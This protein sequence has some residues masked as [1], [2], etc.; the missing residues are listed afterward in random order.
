MANSGLSVFDGINK[1]NY[2]F[3]RAIRNAAKGSP[4]PGVAMA[5]DKSIPTIAEIKA[6]SKRHSLS[7]LLPYESYDSERELY[8]NTDSVGFMLYAFPAVGLSNNQLTILN[9]ILA[10][11]HEVDTQIQI[12]L[13][14]SPDVSAQTTAWANE[15]NGAVNSKNHNV[16]KTLAK[17]RTDYLSTGKWKSLFKDQSWSPRDYHLI[18]SY[19]VTLHKGMLEESL[20]DQFLTSLSDSKARIAGALRGAGIASI[21]LQPE[22]FINLLSGV[23]NPSESTPPKLLYNEN[24]LINDQILDA[25]TAFL[26]GSHGS[27]IRHADASYSVLPFHVRQWPRQWAGFNNGELLGAINNNIT[28]IGY[29]F[30]ATLAVDFG[31]PVNFKSKVK[32]RSLRATQMA[33]SPVSKYVPEWQDR[34]RD[35]DFVSKEIADGSK[36]ADMFYQIVLFAPQGDEQRAEQN[37]K[38]VYISLGWELSKSAYMP[39]HS[40]LAA[41]PMGITGDTKAALKTFGH[42][43]THL[44]S[45]AVNCAPWIGEWK[46]STTAAMLLHGRRGQVITWDPYD[47]KKGNYNIA[48]AAK[49]GAGKSFFSQ[50]IISN[51]LSSGGRAV[52]IDSGH[53]Y[54][55]IAG[56]FDGSYIEFDA[57]N[58]IGLNPFSNIDDSDP[59]HFKEQLPLLKMMLCQ[60]SGNEEKI[61]NVHKA[62]LERAIVKAWSVHKR[63]TTITKVSAAIGDLKLH[64][65]QKAIGEALQLTLYSYTAEGMYG[66]YFEGDSNIS[67]DNDF[68]VLELSGL[69]DTPDLQGVVLLY[70]I[71]RITQRMYHDLNRSQRDICI[72]DEAWKLLRDGMTGE[73]IEEGYR[74]VRKYNGSFITITQA[75]TDYFRSKSAEAAFNNSDFKIYLNQKED[76]LALA[77]ERGYIDNKSGHIDVLKTIETI[78]GQ[79]S[80]MAIVSPDGLSVCRFIID[81]YTEKLYS[82]QAVEVAQI[83]DLIAQGVPLADAVQRLVAE[84]AGR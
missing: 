28:R 82:T 7:S 16:F 75:I 65:S 31:D 25:D 84:G 59:K 38:S 70:L 66:T 58:I 8:F 17:K 77:E 3:K 68:I 9:S 40:L 52:V 29:P 44:T 80:E 72:I 81:P 45:T 22:F 48:I 2:K 10:G 54:R 11:M 62:L 76:V 32:K 19:S 24:D 21:D 18:V 12:T 23:L 43:S 41:L 56:L 64:D 46:G 73:F 53:S 20:D 71:M 67:L 1:L 37:L 27:T 39:V 33:T 34:K 42:Y 74:V 35:W 14:S 50:E 78:H 69:R 57:G 15:R 26:A 4:P 79:Y 60:M 49:S 63:L 13:I 6:F 30:I 83:Q 36:L 47:N 51:T 55:E 5:E 61:T